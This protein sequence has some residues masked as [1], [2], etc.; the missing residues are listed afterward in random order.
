MQIAFLKSWHSKYLCHSS[1]PMCDMFDAMY[2]NGGDVIPYQA[3]SWSST[4]SWSSTSR[5]AKET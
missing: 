5:H 1:V 4:G 3:S 2:Y